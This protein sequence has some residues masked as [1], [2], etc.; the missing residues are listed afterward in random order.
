MCSPRPSVGDA[1][2]N[3]RDSDLPYLQK[4]RLAL[5]NNLTKLRTG[6]GCCGNYGEPGC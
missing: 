6:K 1:W 4:V 3:W 2:D 5:R